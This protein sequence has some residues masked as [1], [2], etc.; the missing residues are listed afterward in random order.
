MVV[1]GVMFSLI[2]SW[3][4]IL[5]LL[6]FCSLIFISLLSLSFYD[7]KK[8]V[9]F[10]TSCHLSLIL[11]FVCCSPGILVFHIITHGF[12]KGTIFIISGA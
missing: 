6:G 12:V 1:A 3:L 9:A 11:S 10:S 5:G 2:V 7:V 4:W 8:V